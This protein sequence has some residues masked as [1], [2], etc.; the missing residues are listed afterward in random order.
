MSATAHVP[1]HG[2]EQSQQDLR[3]VD[4]AHE[5]ST[6]QL[7]ERLRSHHDAGTSTPD[8]ASITRQLQAQI[9]SL[10]LLSRNV[11]LPHKLLVSAGV[12]PGKFVPF[13]QVIRGV[14]VMC[15]HGLAYPCTT[16]FYA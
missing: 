2:V 10:G 7:V 14:S 11:K 8:N 5:N 12:Y 16:A 4:V 9:C 15:Q 3:A 6:Q 1:Q 13:T